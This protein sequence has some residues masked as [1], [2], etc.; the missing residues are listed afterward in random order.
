MDSDSGYATATK[1]LL[2]AVAV[3]GVLTI[4]VTAPN[5]FSIFGKRKQFFRYSDKQIRNATYGLKRR[6]LIEVIKENNGEATIRLNYKEGAKIKKFFFD[7]LSVPKPGKWDTKW[8]IIIFDVPVKF[9]KARMA[10]V[11]KLKEMGFYKLQKSVWVY[12]FPC[13]DEV[14]FVANFFK[15]EKFIEIITAESLLKDIKLKSFFGLD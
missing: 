12:P 13:E 2:S 6:K 5:M 4:A 3:A 14:L 1:V 15:I 9:N 8:R 11:F 7:I 10:M